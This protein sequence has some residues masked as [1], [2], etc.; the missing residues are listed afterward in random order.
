MDD[1]IAEMLKARLEQA[2][3]SP[4]ASEAV[5]DWS[6]LSL[7]TAANA[8]MSM[9]SAFP[10]GG[11]LPAGTLP[12]GALPPG[13]L[14]PGV[15]PPNAMPSMMQQPASSDACAGAS[16]GSAA[17]Q[18]P[19]LGGGA[20]PVDLSGW[21]EEE[22]STLNQLQGQFSNLR[23]RKLIDEGASSQVWEGDWAGARVVI[24]VLREQEAL[25][26]FLSEVNIWRQLRHP[27][28]CALLGVCMF[29]GRPSMVLEYM[30]GGSL[31]DLLHNSSEK[32][33][34]DPMLI[35][36]MVSEVASGVAYL[37]SNGVM[38]RDVKT[39]VS[40]GDTHSHNPHTTL[41]QPSR[42]HAHSPYP[43]PL[44][45]LTIHASARSP[46]PPPSATAGPSAPAA[47][48]RTSCSTTRATPR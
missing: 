24:K 21:T 15:L 30:T 38:H 17:I 36:R 9:E 26:S 37:H 35:S 3:R 34:L 48:L 22:V 1:S 42:M 18:P 46:S 43:R 41:T 4:W 40:G 6:G 14:P 16:T 7:G 8:T 29:D 45:L 28:V 5:A 23:V 20:A 32:G 19:T 10:P 44:S 33:E 31:H 2:L 11:A 13:A 39:A 25:R 12:P 47:A 27:C